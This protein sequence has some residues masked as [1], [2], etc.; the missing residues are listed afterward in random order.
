MKGEFTGKHMLAVLVGGFGIVFAVNFTM[1]AYA[2]GSFSGVVVENSYVA[3]QKYNGWLEEARESDKLGWSV[4]LDR[5]ASGRLAVLTADVPEGA[6]VSAELRRPLGKVEHRSL[7][8]AADGSGRFVS[9]EAVPDGRWIVR[10]SIE[11]AG[12]R[13]AEEREVR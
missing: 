9:G 8:F 12:Q 1:A 7:A 5:E 2:T 3:S 13:W 4:D 6:Q 11:Y 10:L